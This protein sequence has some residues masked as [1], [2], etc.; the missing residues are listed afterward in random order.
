M[1]AT[2]GRGEV[3]CYTHNGKATMISIDSNRLCYLPGD[4]TWTRLGL[5]GRFRAEKLTALQ[6]EHTTC[7]IHTSMSLFL[8]CLQYNLSHVPYPF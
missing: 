4:G 5:E 6:F 3:L 7:V 8:K 1:R 2:A